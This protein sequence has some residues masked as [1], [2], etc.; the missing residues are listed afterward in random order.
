MKKSLSISVLILVGVLFSNTTF[1]KKKKIKFGN[2][3]MEEL[4]MK[5]YS[6]DTSAPAVVLY[7]SGYYDAINHQFIQHRRVKILKKEGYYLADNEFNTTSK[8][9]IKGLT[10]NLKDGKIIESKLDKENIYEE[11]IWDYKYKYNVAMPDVKVG[12]VLDIIVKYDGF[13][14]IWYFQKTIPVVKSEC[15]LG[16]SQYITFRKQEGGIIR[17]NNVGFNH[18]IAED[19]PAFISEDYLNSSNNY[20]CRIEFDIS[21]THFPGYY[22]KEYAYSWKSIN[23]LLYGLNSFGKALNWPNSFL[24]KYA[25]EIEDSATNDKEKVKL[26][27]EKIKSLMVWDERNRI[28]ISEDNLTEVASEKEGSS[29]DINLM[30]VE[31]LQKLNMDV[32]PAV[33]SSRNNGMLHPVNPSLWKLNYVIA[34]VRVDG[35]FIPLDATSD[36]LPYDMLPIRCLNYSCQMLDNRETKKIS[37][38][39]TK[40]YFQR[41]FYDLNL[42]E[43]FSLAGKLSYMSKDYAAYAFRLD[44]EDYLKQEEYVEDLMDA[45][46]GLIIT[47]FTIDNIKILEKPIIEKYDVEI[48]EAFIILDNQAFIN[49]FLYEKIE[50][51]LFKTEDRKYPVDFIY[52]RARS[53]VV[54]IK[55]PENYTIAELPKSAK[56]SLPENSASFTMMYSFSNGVLTLNYKLLINRVVFNESVYSNLREFYAQIVSMQ[57]KP[58]ILNI[59]E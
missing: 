19:M 29:A 8:S 30:L 41:T 12:S 10:F 54:R 45:N 11:K 35:E 15:E 32:Y 36:I 59:N 48:E 43:N 37:L 47:D 21:E 18:W 24:N 14:Y 7:E 28:L 5:V 55:L 58:V 4:A 22:P 2:V 57:D 40:K 33:M 23:N 6:L 31:L 46:N 39:P 42:D 25:K 17:P 53:G 1:A 38:I 13:P 20:L 44:F 26:A 50:E 49:M 34:M 16:D 9:S 27:V 3:S 51:N 52:E 56:I